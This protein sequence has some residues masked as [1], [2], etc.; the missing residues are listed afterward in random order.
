MRLLRLR[1][2]LILRD[3]W[4][5]MEMK[6][7]EDNFKQTLS[8]FAFSMLKVLGFEHILTLRQPHDRGFIIPGAVRSSRNGSH[9]RPFRYPGHSA[10]GEDC[11][12]DPLPPRCGGG[13][14]GPPQGYPNRSP[15]V[16]VRPRGFKLG[17]KSGKD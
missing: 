5:F 14:P 15:G 17:Q 3:N 16:D 2:F 13:M 1:S 7:W 10:G 6:K 9:W 11:S 12:W 4:N 8:F